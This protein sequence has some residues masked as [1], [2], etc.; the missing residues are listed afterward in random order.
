MRTKCGTNKYQ[1]PTHSHDCLPFSWQ[2]KLHAT[3]GKA[4]DW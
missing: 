4:Q 1:A 3:A 2:N